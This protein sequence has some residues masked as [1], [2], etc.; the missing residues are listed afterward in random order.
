ME[1][2]EK[3]II[4]GKEYF[5]MEDSDIAKLPPFKHDN[6]MLNKIDNIKFDEVIKLI[7]PPQKRYK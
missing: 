1:F 2:M 4:D 5:R 3:I 7:G 6:D